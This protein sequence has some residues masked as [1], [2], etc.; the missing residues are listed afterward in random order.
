MKFILQIKMCFNETHSGL[1]Q[2][3]ALS[4]LLFKFALEYAIMKA[5]ENQVWLKLNETYHL[6]AYADDVNLLEDN[7]DAINKNTE[8]LIDA[9]KEVGLEVN[10]EKTKYMVLYHHHNAGQSQDIQI[11]S[12]SFENLSH[13]KYLETTVTNQNVIQ[14]E[15]KWRLN[16]IMLTTI[17]SI[18]SCG[19]VSF[20]KS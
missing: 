11:A 4:P 17:Q 8:T 13:L 15:I 10:V 14:E 9:S 6:L 12:R 1:K 19:L 20:Q 2:G 3:H 5:Q 7:I 18:T 16:F